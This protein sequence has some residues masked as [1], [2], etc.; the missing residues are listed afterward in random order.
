LNKGADVRLADASGATALHYAAQSGNG[1]AVALLLGHGAA[2]NI[3]DFE[4]HTP[5]WLALH[6]PVNY[7]R[8]W[9]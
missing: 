8:T 3:L 4:E 6:R 9:L 1:E 7:S 5:L 2:P